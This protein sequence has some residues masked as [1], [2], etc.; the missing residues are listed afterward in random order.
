MKIKILFL[1][2]VLTGCIHS[3]DSSENDSECTNAEHEFS[4]C[5]ITQ[6][7][8][9]ARDINDDSLLDIWSRAQYNFKAD[10]TLEVVT[11]SYLD[12][13]CTGTPDK[14]QS[15]ND[16]ADITYSV[17][18]E[19]TTEDGIDGTEIEITLGLSDESVV[20][21][22]LIVTDQNELCS[23]E[24]FKFDADSFGIS[25]AGFEEKT[26]IYENCLVRGQLP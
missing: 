13:S 23:S 9:Q 16:I 24:T 14:T 20:R 12:S 18:G 10:G 4:G 1:S 15:A 26:N 17:I 6:G 8:S 19:E 5:W 22:I 2:L 7:C 3:N 21:G 25:Q 11:K